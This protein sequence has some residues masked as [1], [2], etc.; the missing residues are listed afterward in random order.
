M[1]SKSSKASKGAMKLDMEAVERHLESTATTLPYGSA[2]ELS[3]K[4]HFSTR[5]VRELF[6]VF[7]RHADRDGYRGSLSEAVFCDA[8]VEAGFD[9]ER[10]RGE[11]G[12]KRVFA[13]FDHAKNERI[14]FRE[15]LLGLS[16]ASRG[17][18]AEKMALAFDA[19]DI[20]GSGAVSRDELLSMLTGMDRAAREMAAAHAGGVPADE[21][22]A[23]HDDVERFVDALY[24]EHDTDAS[25]E[26]SREQ[27]ERAVMS[28]PSL[29]DFELPDLAKHAREEWVRTGLARGWLRQMPK[30]GILELV[31]E[32]QR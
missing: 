20:E 26:L 14:D 30:T 13:A 12:A 16:T 23:A 4:T 8:L 29:A 17:T 1:G 10:L 2:R 6:D 19:Y 15:L 32:Q 28:H 5:E 25:G 9:V 27:F 18:L 3:A 24:A 22:K 11:I 7:R 31:D 21:A